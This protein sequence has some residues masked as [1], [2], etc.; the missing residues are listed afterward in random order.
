MKCV[1]I[2]YKGLRAGAFAFLLLPVLLF[3]LFFVKPLI[4]IPAAA[5]MLAVY[6]FAI[7]EET[8]SRQMI[9]ISAG[10]LVAFFTICLVWCY[11]GGQGGLFYQTSDW[12]ERNA[13]FRDL[14][15]YQWPVYYPETDTML[16]YYIGHWLPAASIGRLIYLATGNLDQAFG[17]GNLFLAMWSL[18][19]VFVTL[20]LHLCTVSPKKARGQWLVLLMFIGFSGMDIIGC[21][22]MKWTMDDIFRILHLEWWLD[23]YQFSSNTTCL[24]WV[25]NQAITAW[26]ATLCFVNENNNRNY[27]FIIGCSLLSA[28]LPCVGLAILMIG[29]VI[30]D[31]LAAIRKHRVWQYIKKTFSL[32]NVA[33][34]VFWVPIIG[35]YLMSNSALENTVDGE[36]QATVQITE[37]MQS[38]SW[39]IIG[40]IGVALLIHLIWRIVNKNKAKT[41]FFLG[42]AVLLAVAT[43][44]IYVFPDTGKAYFAFLALECGIYWLLLARDYHAAPMYYIIGFVFIIAPCIKVGIGSDFCMRA[45]IPALTI[46]MIMCSKKLCRW[47]ERTGETKRSLSNTV[48]CVLLSICLVIGMFTPAMEI[49]RG[50][51]IVSENQQVIMPADS[52][53]TLNQYHSSGGIYGN[54][55]S[56]SYKDAIFFKYFA[57]Q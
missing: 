47:I 41:P 14:I 35:T 30:F 6:I 51:K 21:K 46:L 42:T 10:R 31:V 24:F 38:F 52:I 40:L 12:N 7:R 43:S 28:S 54:F 36:P 39:I 50:I 25:F 9:H 16:T 34:V 22:I 55:V 15:Q 13:I 32:S 56:D 37:R 20:L 29:R 3:L 48:T 18:F 5:V 11:L 4:G 27:A 33:T 8:K 23:R 19:G 2:T 17:I 26:V 45:S 49:Y 57:R 1:K 53:G 44:M